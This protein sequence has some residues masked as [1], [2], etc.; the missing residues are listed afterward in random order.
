MLW[1]C[2]HEMTCEPVC[3]AAFSDHV[4]AL[5]CVCDTTVLFLGLASTHLATACVWGELKTYSTE[6]MTGH[7]AVDGVRA[8]HG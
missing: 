1:V 3:H 6:Q 4:L 2:D 8:N 5:L 7:L